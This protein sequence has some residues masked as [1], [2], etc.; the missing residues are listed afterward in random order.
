MLLCDIINTVD[1]LTEIIL[2]KKQSNLFYYKLF[3]LTYKEQIMNKLYPNTI[4]S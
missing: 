3:L 4:I 1:Y 2:L